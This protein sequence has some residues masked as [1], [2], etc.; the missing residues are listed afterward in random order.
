MIRLIATVS[1]TAMLLGCS[2]PQPFDW[3]ATVD[4]TDDT[5]DPTDPNTS[6]NSMFA[7]D[8]EAGLTMNSVEYDR[9]KNDLVINNLPFDGP[10]GRYDFMARIGG[11]KVF[12]SRQTATTGQV[13]HYAVFVESEHIEAAAAAGANWIEYGYGG[14]N[15]NRDRSFSLPRSG[16]YVYIGEYA[17]VRTFDDRGGLEL[18]SGDVRIILDVNDFDPVDGIQGALTGTVYNRSISGVNGERPNRLS[19]LYL[20]VT[21]FSTEEG[22]FKDGSATTF[23]ESG[24]ADASGTFDGFLAGP[25]GTDIGGHVVITGSAY[26][27]LVTYDVVSYQVTTVTPAVVIG[28]VEI[29]AE[30]SSTVTGTISALDT[31][32]RT[33]AQNTVNNGGTVGHLSV[34]ASELPEGAEIVETNVRDVLFVSEQNAR[35]IGVLVGER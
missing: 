22:V 31:D 11:V 4:V 34:N 20:A 7:Y 15:I 30:Q 28:G 14:A 33:Q 9:E 23:L 26:N 18:V 21:S 27:E 16:E 2:A 5:I 3:G 19:P 32:S 6:V 12:E 8:R 17:A 13:K 35:E 25:S 1:A 29:V 10:A 24:D